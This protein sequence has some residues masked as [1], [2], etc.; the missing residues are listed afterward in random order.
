MAIASYKPDTASPVRVDLPRV[1]KD[2]NSIIIDNKQ[3]P[4]NTL[5]T[6]IQGSHWTVDYYHQIT[7]LD[8][9]VR[10]S[11]PTQS[12]IYQQYNKIT[13]FDLL[14]DS[15]LSSSQNTDNTL[16]SVKGSSKVYPVIVPNVGD[17][18]KA[19]LLNGMIGIFTITEV[20]RLSFNKDS[21]YLIDYNLYKYVNDPNDQDLK[22]IESK[23]IRTY[24]FSKDR[25]I[26]GSMPLLNTDEYTKE[27]S[28]KEYG[29]EI[30]QYLF[31]SFFNRDLMT[32]VIPGQDVFVYDPMLLSFLRKLINN[33]QAPEIKI[34]QFLNTEGDPYLDQP[35]VLDAILNQDI[36]ML[37][38]VNKE[39]KL[40]DPRYFSL[41]AY[42]NSIYYTGVQ[43]IVY[44]L[45]ITLTPN[46]PKTNGPEIIDPLSTI[47]AS[48][49]YVPGTGIEPTYT[50]YDGCQNL[51]D[52]N[53]NICGVDV[54]GNPLPNVVYGPKAECC[55]DIVTILSKLIPTTGM[56]QRLYNPVLDVYD[57]GV[58]KTPY[59]YDVLYDGYYVLSNNFYSQTDNQSVLESLVT[60]LIKGEAI[61]IDALYAV[62]KT[63]TKWNRLEQYYYIPL[64]Y[65]LIITA[66]GGLY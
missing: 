65:A 50:N 11:D 9:D 16:M 59:T 32:I 47:I 38:Y 33:D 14:V 45:D 15:A 37:D 20:E 17:I 41:N 39:M 36:S 66:I 56:H 34:T 13:G 7:S 40:V 4:L 64:L 42:L 5:L 27:K 8:T 51:L 3:T 10:T 43:Y 55:G 26:N 49:G 35:T 30:I 53:K 1:E 54:N 28:L 23:V 24:A 57:D 22:T 62:C 44:P 19:T 31:R 46:W 25:L 12:S 29:S 61:N 58:H 48:N 18:F 52:T 63:Y 2:Y 21:V 6:Y 60:Q